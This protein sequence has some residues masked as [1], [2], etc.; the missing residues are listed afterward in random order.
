M[1][2]RLYALAA[3]AALPA[4]GPALAQSSPSQFTTFYRYDGAGEETGVISPDPDGAGPLPFPAVR[5]TY[6]PAGRLVKVEEGRLSAWQPESVAPAAWSG[7]AADRTTASA[8]DAM[9]RK[10][11]DVVSGS[12]G[13]TASVTDYSY[14]SAGRLLCTAIRMNPAT[15]GTAPVDACTATSPG[16]AG[17]D[18]ISRNSY[19]SADQLL[20]VEKGVLTPLQQ[21]Y[22]TYEYDLDGRQSAVTDAGGNRA[23]L[24]YDGLG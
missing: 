24:R 2:A 16:S 14:D 17:P 10:L 23:E 8:Y 3:L 5:K 19:D 12:D 18:R 1:S 7:F 22:A 11:R 20:K 9:D 13:T 21:A 6:D 4:G 15:W